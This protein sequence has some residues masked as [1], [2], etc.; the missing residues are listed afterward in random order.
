MNPVPEYGPLSGQDVYGSDPTLRTI[1]DSIRVLHKAKIA[2]I[3]CDCCDGT[4]SRKYA[5]VL[6]NAYE[7]NSPLGFPYIPCCSLRLPPNEVCGGLDWVSKTYF[8]R[9]VMSRQSMCFTCKFFSGPGSFH[10]GPTK[11][12]CCFNPCFDLCNSVL[13]C[14]S[15]RCCGE[16]IQYVPAETCCWCCPTRSCWLFNCFGLCGPQN[17]EPLIMLPFAH[18]LLLG[19]SEELLKSLEKARAEWSQKTS[20]GL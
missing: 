4:R 14:H 20:R 8:D 12:T 19:E 6:E 13:S 1:G 15:Y 11:F 16:R 2:S 7:Q 17:G 10:A 3:C 18:H 5:W 9:G